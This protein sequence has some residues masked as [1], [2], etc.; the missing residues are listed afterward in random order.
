[1][2][3][4]PTQKSASPQRVNSHLHNAKVHDAHTECMNGKGAAAAGFM[5]V[6]LESTA[7]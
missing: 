5:P 2:R 1:M 7:S 4:T 3:D 6:G